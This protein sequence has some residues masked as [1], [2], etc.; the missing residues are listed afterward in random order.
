MT[1]P[2][3]T[4]VGPLLSFAERLRFPRLALL[5][6]VVFFVDL[7]VPDLIPFIDEIILG[8]L[9]LMLTRWKKRPVGA[10]VDK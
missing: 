4:P 9:T 3:L 1:P 6:A 8:L 7:I 2:R 10:E 5:T